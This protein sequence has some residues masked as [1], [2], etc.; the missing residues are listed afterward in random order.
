MFLEPKLILKYNSSILIIISL[1]SYYF[2]TSVTALIPFFFGCILSIVY[3]LYDKNN[4]LFAHIALLVILLLLFG[5]WKP[6]SSAF[7]RH[8][9]FAILRVGTMILFNLYTVIC[10][11]NSF[12]KARKI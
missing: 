10:F 8:D 12:I 1:I 5:L 7:D 4:K 9:N 2:S 6:F 3:F 11:V